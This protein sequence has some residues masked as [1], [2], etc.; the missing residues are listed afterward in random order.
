[1][2]P[3]ELLRRKVEYTT[4][5]PYRLFKHIDI[6]EW[7]VDDDAIEA[8]GLVR[9]D[10]FKDFCFDGRR[11][12]SLGAVYFKGDA[13]M[14]LQSAGREGDDYTNEYIINK[15]GQKEL[16]AYI[17]SKTKIETE[18]S[19][20]SYGMDED[21]LCLTSFYSNDLDGPFEHY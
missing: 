2:T 18:D 20:H 3:R 17:R 11:S 8:E 19:I 16:C 5:D 7:S 12:W 13:V 4:N 15:D 14:I 10:W 21:I 9:I 6:D 1:M